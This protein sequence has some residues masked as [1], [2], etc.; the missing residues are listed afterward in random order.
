MYYPLILLPYG[1]VSDQNGHSVSMLLMWQVYSYLAVKVL[2]CGEPIKQSQWSLKVY[3][4]AVP[5]TSTSINYAYMNL[6]GF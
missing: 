6:G 4:V 1:A 2:S 3:D 5:P